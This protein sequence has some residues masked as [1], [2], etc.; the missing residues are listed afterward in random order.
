MS[1]YFNIDA[2]LAEEEPITAEFKTPVFSLSSD[3]TLARRPADARTPAAA[4]RA[5]TA[6]TG[7][8]I[9][10]NDIPAG[11][12]ARMPLWLVRSMASK[13]YVKP[14][15]PAMVGPS[16]MKEFKENPM[17]PNLKAKCPYYY[18]VAAEVASCTSGTD[19]QRVK[20]AALGLYQARYVEVLHAGDKLGHDL[21][22]AVDKMENR[23]A[24]LVASLLEDRRRKAA[25]QAQSLR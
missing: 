8:G 22:D 16:S 4:G 3:V 9:G 6:T 23:E 17:T 12:A 11:A 25:W 15:V 13:G 24:R 20:R 18:D 7:S 21:V 2:I 19:G 5:S 1:R 10:D 14:D